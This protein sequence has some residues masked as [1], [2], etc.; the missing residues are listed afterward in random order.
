MGLG[1]PRAL[2]D[3]HARVPNPGLTAVQVQPGSLVD[4][5]VGGLG[6]ILVTPYLSKSRTVPDLP[7]GGV[8]FDC[9][10][11]EREGRR[12]GAL[13]RGILTRYGRRIECE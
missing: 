9:I 11:G 7:F 12:A 10:I 13:L 2:G 6:R 4:G 5:T 3:T 1:V 8:R